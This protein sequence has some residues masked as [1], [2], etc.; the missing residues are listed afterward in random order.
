MRR[1]ASLPT[2]RGC[3]KRLHASYRAID[4]H[5]MLCSEAEVD[6]RTAGIP[7]ESLLSLLMEQKQFQLSSSLSSGKTP[8]RDDVRAILAKMGCFKIEKDSIV[9]RDDKAKIP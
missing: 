4:A 6:P 1:F 2:A 3:A 7:T 5:Y 9:L 8:S